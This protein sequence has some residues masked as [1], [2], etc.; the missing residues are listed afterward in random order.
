VQRA[1]PCNR[2][3]R[4]HCTPLLCLVSIIHCKLG[5]QKQH[6]VLVG[7][8]HLG[9]R[10][11][12]LWPKGEAKLGCLLGSGQNHDCCSPTFAAHRGMRQHIKQ[13]KAAAVFGVR[14]GQLRYGIAQ[15]HA[16]VV[17]HWLCYSFALLQHGVCLLLLRAQIVMATFLAVT[18]CHQGVKSPC[19][20]PR[21]GVLPAL[22]FTQGPATVVCGDKIYWPAVFPMAP[23]HFTNPHN[24]PCNSSVA[25]QILHCRLHCPPRPLLE[26]P[27]TLALGA[28]CSCTTHA[29]ASS[30]SSLCNSQRGYLVATFERLA[31][32]P[33]GDWSLG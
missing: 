20:L 28:C 24:S 27:C 11:H 19:V 16:R 30:G 17:Q 3:Q 31:V 23:R 18:T 4:C 2:M 13:R 26:E 21:R 15:Q 22:Y 8:W 1:I 5:V 14:T 12:H 33:R 7:P 6:R 9:V 25:V 10:Q 32:L 29:K